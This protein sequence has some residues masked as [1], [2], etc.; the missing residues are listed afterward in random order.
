[1]CPIGFVKIMASLNEN[2]L[3]F[4]ANKNKLISLESNRNDILQCWKYKKWS[5]PVARTAFIIQSSIHDNKSDAKF[6]W[7]NSNDELVLEKYS[8]GN[9]SQHFYEEIMQ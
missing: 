3:L 5:S 9:G 4:T 2:Y 1:M 7:T 6:V 8:Q